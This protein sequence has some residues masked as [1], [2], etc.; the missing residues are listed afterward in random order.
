MSFS[1]SKDKSV[2]AVYKLVKA[3]IYSHCFSQDKS[4]LAVTCETDCLVYRV[5][6]NTPPVLFATLKDHDKTITAVDIS[7]MVVL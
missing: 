6:N 4:I 5:S 3:P 2:V 1:N 7:Y